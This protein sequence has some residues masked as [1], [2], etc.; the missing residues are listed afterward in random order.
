MQ[1]ENLVKTSCDANNT[2]PVAF[3]PMSLPVEELCYRLKLFKTLRLL[4]HEKPYHIL[5]LLIVD[6]K[7]SN[8]A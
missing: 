2:L 7:V 5:V 8:N 1:E 6:N 3:D 4:L